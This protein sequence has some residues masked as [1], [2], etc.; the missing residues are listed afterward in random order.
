MK[1]L[2]QRFTGFAALAALGIT[3]AQAHDPD[4]LAEW[5]KSSASQSCTTV[6]YVEKLGTDICQL[7]VQCR[8]GA[9]SVA[10]AYKRQEKPH[11]SSTLWYLDSVKDLVNNGGH[12]SGGRAA[13]APAKVGARQ[14][15]PD[16]LKKCLAACPAD[17]P[18]DQSKSLQHMM[19]ELTCDNKHG[20]ERPQ[21]LQ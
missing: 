7:Q 10:D 16:L 12:L 4:C 9:L 8:T 2:A 21:L 15:D 6:E 1:S 3:A 11:E 14:P 13:P 5:K 17:T 19:C 18:S 20:P